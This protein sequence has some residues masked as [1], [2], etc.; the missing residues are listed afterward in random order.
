MGI[1]VGS[2]AHKDDTPI[3]GSVGLNKSPCIGC[4]G[5]IDVCPVKAISFEK[6]MGA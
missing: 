2:Y 1:D 6:I 5:C 3:E 4:G